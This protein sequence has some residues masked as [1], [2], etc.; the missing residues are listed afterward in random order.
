MIQHNECNPFNDITAFGFAPALSLTD[1]E[2]Q[3]ISSKN[4]H[5]NYWLPLI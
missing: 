2:R 3:Q 5:P 1:S 4:K